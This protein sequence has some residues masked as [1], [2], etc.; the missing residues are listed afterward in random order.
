MIA[1]KHRRAYP[2]EN[3]FHKRRMEPDYLRAKKGIRPA[4]PAG[5]KHS[6]SEPSGHQSR[7]R[8]S[9]KAVPFFAKEIICVES[10]V[11]TGFRRGMPSEL[12]LLSGSFTAPSDN[13]TFR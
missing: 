11:E 2:G 7:R 3:P 4:A 10:R 13:P 12:K 1:R 9:V 8:V 6:M 5:R